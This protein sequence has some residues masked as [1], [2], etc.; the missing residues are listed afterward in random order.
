MMPVWPLSQARAI[1]ATA[2]R[3]GRCIS[4]P[5]T[6][7]TKA[8][9]HE[10]TKRSGAGVLSPQSF[11]ALF[12]N[13]ASRFNAS[14]GVMFD[15]SSARSAS[16]AGWG[17][18]LIEQRQLSRVR[19]RWRG[20]L[21][22]PVRPLERGEHGACPGHH[23]IGEPRELRHVHTVRPVGA[24]GF[25]PMEEYYRV[26]GFA[27]GHVEVAGVGQPLRELHQLVIVGGEHRLAAD[28]VVQVLADRPGD[29]HAVV[30]AGAAADL[31][32]Q[33]EGRGASRYGEW[34]W[35][36]PFPP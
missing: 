16:R 3:T 31:V 4:A 11:P 36:R 10:S 35:S 7:Y 2:S 25:E 18:G 27:H 14:S 32:E 20:A 29:G 6:E 21:H 23:R 15:T 26:P 19:F 34:R 12:C 30:G 1:R 8:R 9:N 22:H 33:D 5:G 17:A 24:A 28:P 13:S